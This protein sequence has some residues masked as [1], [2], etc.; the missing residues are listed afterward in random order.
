MIWFRKNLP[1]LVAGLVALAIGA[2]FGWARIQ[3]KLP[4]SLEPLW[5][6]QLTDLRG[7]PVRMA[8]MRGKPLIVNFWATWCGPCKEE[9]PD[10]QRLA[11]GEFG[12]QIQIVGI[13]IDNADNMRAF[14]EKIGITYTLLEGG[15]GSLDMIKVLGN[16]VGG[17]PFTLVIDA[18]GK[19]VMVSLGRV[20]YDD[21]KNAAK[22][23]I[24]D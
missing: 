18:S 13:G 24:K 3:A 1:L 14:A 11:T 23:A 19:S 17:L 6:A 5:A 15:A 21:L 2:W 22:T 12:N 10:F 4:P 9:M 20:S 8:S 7:N 16:H